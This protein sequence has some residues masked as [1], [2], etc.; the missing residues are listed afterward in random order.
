MSNNNN[1]S[2]ITTSL[3]LTTPSK[4]IS[5]PRSIPSR[6][7]FGTL[8]SG[9]LGAAAAGG[10]LTSPHSSRI[11][12]CSSANS[13]L[14]LPTSSNNRMMN[15]GTPRIHYPPSPT[16]ISLLED[17]VLFQQQLSPKQIGK[18]L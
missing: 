3:P 1:H 4:S 6:L 2:N 5:S 9:G 15:S 16:T 11:N 14:N 10:G 18:F 17:S 13:P 8:E 7:L 12:G